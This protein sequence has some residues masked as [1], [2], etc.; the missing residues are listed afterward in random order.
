MD[1]VL[2]DLGEFSSA[3]L[4]DVIVYS[5]TWQEHIEHLRT[6]L[7]RIKEAGLT[8]KSRKCQLGMDH[9]VYLGHVIGRGL[10][11]LEQSKLM[12]YELGKRQ[13][14]RKMCVSSLG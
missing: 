2:R 5:N 10:V 13:R 6:V 3:Y 9:C 1:E 11:Q 14:R 8:V 12:P 4:D 7:R